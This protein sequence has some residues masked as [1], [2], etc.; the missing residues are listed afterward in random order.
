MKLKL[1]PKI[2]F[3]KNDN[4]E[5]PLQRDCMAKV[6]FIKLMKLANIKSYFITLFLLKRELIGANFNYRWPLSLS[7]LKGLPF[8]SQS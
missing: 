8:H 6:Y 1:V 4:D 2:F 7:K 3:E 5:W